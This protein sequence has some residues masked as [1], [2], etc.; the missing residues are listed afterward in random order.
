V[1]KFERWSRKL[2]L[3]DRDYILKSSRA[4]VSFV[5]S[6]KE[7]RLS[8]ILK[9]KNFDVYETARSFFLFKLPKIR[10][11][12]ELVLDKQLATTEEL[13]LFEKTQFKDK[14]QEKMVKEKIEEAKEKRKGMVE[15]RTVR[16]EKAEKEQDKR[17]VR[18]KAE[19][20]RAKLR[21]NENQ[22]NE[23]SQEQKLKRKLALGKLTKSDYETTLN[24][25]DKKHE[26]KVKQK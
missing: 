15:K 5:R 18:S 21:E 6:F 25:I 17:K 22:F 20:N 13:A 8:N 16:K 14:N 23:F 24:K 10:E 9:F 4:F 7:H 12:L 19:R 3:T 26:Y 2:I 1:G 11:T